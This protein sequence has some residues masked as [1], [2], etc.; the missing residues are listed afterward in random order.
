MQHGGRGPR[1][2][3]ICLGIPAEFRVRSTRTSTSNS[4]SY[5]RYVSNTTDRPSVPTAVSI[6]H[7]TIPA[8]PTC[9]HPHVQTATLR[10]P[11]TIPALRL[12]SE[13]HLRLLL[14]LGSQN[15]VL[16][17][18]RAHNSGRGRRIRLQPRRSPCVRAAAVQYH[19][20]SD[21]RVDE[22]GNSRSGQAGICWSI[23]A[24]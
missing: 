12:S 1:E 18:C 13:R 23:P 22:Q 5:T 19:I 21:G 14:P 7:N 9:Y 20:S 6:I 2:G 3:K 15:N 4:S 10:R 8:P 17:R 24:G 11:P 16:P